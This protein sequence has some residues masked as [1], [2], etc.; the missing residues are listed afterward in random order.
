MKAD[1]KQ[2]III[3]LLIINLVG[4]GLLAAFR[5]I[6]QD[7]AARGTLGFA[8]A[9]N[10]SYTLYI[11]TND[12]DTYRQI[13]PT[14]QAREIVN[15]ICA[16]HVEGYT[17]SEAQGGWVDW[18]GVLTQENTLVYTF[19]GVSEAQL[20]PLMDEVLAA[21]NQSSILVER[22][23]VDSVFYSGGENQ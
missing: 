17:V 16:R 9:E 4:T 12:K 14:A 15:G 5:W 21:L 2:A 20:I 18:E 1:R 3:A 10:G 6:P 7:N 8:Y 23:G 13:I 11:G 19:I 22:A